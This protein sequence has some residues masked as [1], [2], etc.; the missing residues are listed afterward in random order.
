M[1]SVTFDETIGG[2]GSTVSDDDD[3]ATGLLNGGHLVRFV[4]ALV[5]A[6]ACLSYVFE[7]L[8]SAAT[9]AADAIAA[10]SDAADSAAEA[11][12]SA[13]SASFLSAFPVGAI[14]LSATADNPGAFLGGTWSQV[15]AGRT[16]IGVGTLG[17]DT[18][19][20]GDTG[21]E[22]RHTLTTSEIPSHGHGG[23]TGA[24]GYHSHGGN[25]GA[26]GDHNHG[27][28]VRYGTVNDQINYAASWASAG[29][30]ESAGTA[31][32]TGAIAGAGNHQHSIGGDGNHAHGISAEGGGQAHESRMPYL[33]VY[34]WQRTA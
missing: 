11:A 27:L 1:A 20:A 6:V 4:P 8:S 28:R 32:D 10:A 33:A 26:V 29:D 16:L 30:T 24:A 17:S 9:A 14:Y 25:T 7:Q 22:A 23:A 15:A 21:G 31:T 3:P 18:Y 12:A 5:Q 34:F 13:E 19:A 2:D